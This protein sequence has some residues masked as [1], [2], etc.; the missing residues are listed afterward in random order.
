MAVIGAIC[1]W[2]VA[3]AI[4]TVALTFIEGIAVWQAFAQ[5]EQAITE[6]GD[7]PGASLPED[8]RERG[9]A[10]AGH[11]AASRGRIST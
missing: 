11:L 7:P 3:S 10:G 1:Q 2:C 6:T 4:L 5:S 9:T 8:S